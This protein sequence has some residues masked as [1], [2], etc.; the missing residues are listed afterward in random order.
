MLH[1]VD[2]LRAACAADAAELVRLEDARVQEAAAVERRTRDD[3]EQAAQ[4]SHGLDDPHPLGGRLRAQLSALEGIEVRHE[5]AGSAPASFDEAVSEWRVLAR[6]VERRVAD[7]VEERTQ[8]EARVFK[9]RASSP[10]VAAELWAALDRLD[11]IHRCVPAL[12][13]SQVADALRTHAGE[14]ERLL[15]E[16]KARHVSQVTLQEEVVAAVAAVE[17]RTGLAS[18]PWSDSAWRSPSPVKQVEQLIRL[19]ELQPGVPGRPGV[20]AV[21]A[22]VDWPLQ[23]GI[24]VAADVEG[25]QR[26]VGLVKAVMLRV[27]AAVPAGQVH[28][29]V[30]DPVSLGQSVAEFR[31]LSEYGSQL[32]DEKTWTSQ[33]DIERLMEE[34]TSHLEVVISTY[35]RGQFASIDEYNARAGEVAQPYRVLVVLD[36]PRGFSDRAAQQLLSLVENG[37]RCGVYTVLHHEE[38]AVGQEHAGAIPTA[39]LT[40]GMHRVAVRGG[41]ARLSLADP[42]GDVDLGFV[43][44]EAPPLAFD[45]EGRA[46]T[47]CALLLTRI[48]EEVRTRLTSPPAVTLD[49]LL[50]VLAGT[51]TGTV[52][53]YVDAAPAL[54]LDPDSWWQAHTTRKAVALLGRSGAQGVAAAHFSSTEVAGG[55]IMV[56]LPRSGK[57]TS[58]HSLILSMAMLYPPD[59]LELYLIDAKHGV[60]FKAY[61][62]LP[63]ARMVSVRSDREFSLAV[64]QSI[65]ATIRERAELMKADGSGR[66]N[67]TEFRDATGTVLPRVVVVIDEFH[68]LF[69]EPDRTGQLAFAAFSDIVRMGPFSGVHLVVASQTLSSMPAMDRPTLTLLPQRVAFMCNEYDADIVMGDG[70][71]APRLLSKTGEGLFNPSRGEESRNQLFQGLFIDVVERRRLLDQLDRKAT[72]AG[73]H[74]RPRVFDGDA[75]VS[76]PPAAAA[77]RS[78]RSL[79]VPIGEPYTLKDSE[80]V[81]LRRTRGG[82]ALLLA[83]RDDDVVHDE[84]VRGALSSFLIAA[85]HQGVGTTVVDFLVDDDDLPGGMTL[86]EIAAAVGAGYVRAG[87]SGDVIASAEDLVSDRSQQERY[88][89]PAEL[90]VL[91]GLHR[92]T[93]LPTYDEYEPSLSTSL[94]TVVRD[95]PEVGVHVLVCTDRVA[96][97]QRVLG[98]GWPDCFHTRVAGAGLDQSDVPVVTG[99]YGDLPKLRS[100]QLLIGDARTGRALRVRGYGVM[101][102]SEQEEGGTVDSS[103]S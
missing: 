23:A 86:Q 28:L 16:A 67:I 83:G 43:P 100:G 14:S 69:E 71:R 31:H 36:Y 63:H 95:G 2:R 59:E 62:T 37:P 25:R 49:S 52:P 44:D 66:T 17:A 92:A 96:T 99:D 68:E 101:D 91:Y 24:A 77:A 54:S 48:G 80:S 58:L 102:G 38:G 51:R 42:I 5:P 12:R 26:A 75:V 41:S 94:L 22:L 79:A 1:A 6:D 73:L 3:L 89:D 32:V 78:S 97:V 82:N 21:P 60:E 61:E 57:T 85:R 8:W 39:R 72:Q 30:V 103:G 88:K 40:H 11:L 50:P 55:A 18:S 70:N 27:L 87:R 64:L 19:G 56:G 33:R 93:G 53:D 47:S 81:L 10:Q 74:R 35:L 4:R 65:T 20:P 9:R 84:A 13:E 76:R 7:F 98:D 34:L 29:K 15:S 90:L 46:A 45:A